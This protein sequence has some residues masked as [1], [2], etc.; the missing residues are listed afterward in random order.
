MPYERDQAAAFHNCIIQQLPAA[1]DEF[2]FARFARTALM[3]AKAFITSGNG[4]RK[5]VRVRVADT[6]NNETKLFEL[7][8][9]SRSPEKL[10]KL[11]YGGA[12]ESVGPT[13]RKRNNGTPATEGDDSTD[14]DSD[15]DSYG[16]GE[17]WSQKRQYRSV[18]HKANK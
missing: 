9:E 12:T 16:E 11:Y 4:K 13:K 18:N 10:A 15:S 14:Y 7:Q 5:I 6:G 3:L 1:R 2:L 17:D 8:P